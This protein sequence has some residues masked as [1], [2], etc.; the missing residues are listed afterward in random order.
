[1]GTESNVV[2]I[3]GN[4]CDPRVAAVD[5]V[6]ALEATLERARAGELIG[7]VIVGLHFDKS[8]GSVCAG[9]SRH[10]ALVGAVCKVLHEL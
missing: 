4:D 5:V 1:M 2:T 8:T 10:N 9:Q 7:I 3:Y 6:T